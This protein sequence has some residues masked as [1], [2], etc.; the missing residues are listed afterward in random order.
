ML[1]A[2]QHHSDDSELRVGLSVIVIHCVMPAIK[3]SWMH[4]VCLLRCVIQAN[5]SETF[6]NV[7]PLPWLCG[8]YTHTDVQHHRA[9]GA[10]WQN[11]P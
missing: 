8:P 3:V 6:R 10:G 7:L 1:Q 5:L 9:A 11:C 4:S 2:S